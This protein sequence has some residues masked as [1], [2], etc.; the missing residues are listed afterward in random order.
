M[1]LKQVRSAIEAYRLEPHST[2]A[3]LSPN[4]FPPLDAGL[5][6]KVALGKAV[7]SPEPCTAEPPTGPNHGASM[8]STASG[9][10]TGVTSNSVTPFKKV[11]SVLGRQ[12]L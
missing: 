10:L 5:E 12:N 7:V 8:Q 11:S 3:D 4:E 2:R 6:F 9:A 1:G